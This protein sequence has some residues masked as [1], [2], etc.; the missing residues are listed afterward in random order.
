[1]MGT[2]VPEIDILRVPY[3]FPGDYD[4]VAKVMNHGPAGEELG[5]GLAKISINIIKLDCKYD[6][7]I[8]L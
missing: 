4:K 3:F 2:F 7:T 8:S 6:G 5:K 1:M